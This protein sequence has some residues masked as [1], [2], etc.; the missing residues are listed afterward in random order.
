VFSEQA[1]F[2]SFTDDPPQP[3]PPWVD[4]DACDDGLND[5]DSFFFIFILFSLFDD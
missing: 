5:D 2:D 4:E 3:Q 1:E